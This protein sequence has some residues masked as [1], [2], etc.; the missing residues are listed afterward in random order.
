MLV[1]ALAEY[2]DRELSAELGDESWE[3]KPV[4]YLI[5]LDRDGTFLNST[6]RFTAM[7][8]GKKTIDLALPLL[9]PRWTKTI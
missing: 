2:A 5:E 1:Q 4:P 9:V 7:T 3:E 6:S 8:R